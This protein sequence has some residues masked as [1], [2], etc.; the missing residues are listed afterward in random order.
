M[1]AFYENR[2]KKYVL[3]S[4]AI[5][6]AIGVIFLVWFLYGK[7]AY[8]NGNQ[9]GNI[10]AGASPDTS[11]LQIYYYDG[12]TV[13]VRTLYD[14]DKEKKL[15]K[16]INAF[17]LSETDQSVVA[18]MN[19]P[20]YGIWIGGEDGRDISVTWSDGIWLRNGGST[21]YGNA[22]FSGWWEELAGEDEDDTL[23]VLGFPNAGILS[24]YHTCFMVEE[25]GLAE[26]EDSVTMTIE[27]ILADGKTKVTI[28]NNSGEDFEYGEYFSLQKQIDGHWYTIP[29]KAENI[30]FHDICH[31]LP[32][33]EMAEETYDISI[34]DSL[35]PG[36]YR[37]VVEGLSAEFAVTD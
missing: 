29:V 31:I 16:R 14:S 20:F 22:D 4:A 19:F 9:G 36:A 27:E 13:A 37:L 5:L 8:G 30:G 11:A 15:L 32:A 17:V 28:T 23:N 35:E 10:L 18:D 1:G 34:F 3:V 33:G 7:V 21:F 25:D 12:E 2:G 6:L 26:S 24:E